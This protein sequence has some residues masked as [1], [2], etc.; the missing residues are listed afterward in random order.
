M[1]FHDIAVHQRP[2]R[3]SG[4]E[5]YPGPVAPDDKFGTRVSHGTIFYEFL[6]VALVEVG[7]PNRNRKGQGDR[8]GNSNLVN[9][10][11]GVGCNYSTRRKIDA[12]SHQVTANSALLALQSHLNGL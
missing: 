5:V 9:R 11:V 10:Q 6:H 7:H 8:S 1:A 3:V 4:G 2:V 12:L